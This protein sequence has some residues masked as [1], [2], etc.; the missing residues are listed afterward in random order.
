MVLLKYIHSWA[1]IGT[2][3]SK[4]NF[5]NLYYLTGLGACLK[6]ESVKTNLSEDN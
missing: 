2:Y 1:N 4:P 6:D 5:A 3:A